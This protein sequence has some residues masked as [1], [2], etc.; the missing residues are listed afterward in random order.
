MADKGAH[1]ARSACG[2]CHA[3]VPEVGWIRLAVTREGV[4]TTGMRGGL[5]F[6]DLVFCS[7]EH[8]ASFLTQPLPPLRPQPLP[9]PRSPVR[10]GFELS[11]IIAGG[12]VTLGL[13]ALGIWTIVQWLVAG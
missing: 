9:A 4:L 13:I 8:A 7:Q 5:E 6:L 10:E 2:F 3:P 1:E 12:V 11:A